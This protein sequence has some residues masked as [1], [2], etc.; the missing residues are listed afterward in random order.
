MALKRVTAIF[1]A[2]S[3]DDDGDELAA[4]IKLLLEAAG[5]EVET[6]ETDDPDDPSEGGDTC[7]HGKTPEQPCDECDGSEDDDDDGEPET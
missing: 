7:E 3:G 6:I 1:T 4:Q 2:E 5:A